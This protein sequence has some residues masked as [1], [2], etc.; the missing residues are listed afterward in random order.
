MNAVITYNE[1]SNN[2]GMDEAEGIISTFKFLIDLASISINHERQS[3]LYLLN[4]EREL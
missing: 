4:H 3:R 1:C 2:G